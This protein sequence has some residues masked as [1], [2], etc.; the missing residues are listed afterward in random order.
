M[1][2]GGR[3]RTTT[4]AKELGLPTPGHL[5]PSRSFSRTVKLSR[6]SPSTPSRVASS[7]NE[8]HQDIAELNPVGLAVFRGAKAE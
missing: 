3:G 5:S 6:S 8:F 4:V 2:R 7:S 1:A